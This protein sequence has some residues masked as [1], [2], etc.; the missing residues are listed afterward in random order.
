MK[1]ELIEGSEGNYPKE[2]ILHFYIRILCSASLL[3]VCKFQFFLY[4]KFLNGPILMII[5]STQQNV[6]VEPSVHFI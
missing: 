2:N 4:V 3:I 1:M 6:C 5:N